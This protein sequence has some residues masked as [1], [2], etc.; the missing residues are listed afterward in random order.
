MRSTHVYLDWDK[1]GTFHQILE[2]LTPLG[3]VDWVRNRR[4]TT[5]SQH[6]VQ[7]HTTPD[8]RLGYVDSGTWAYTHNSNLRTKGGTPH[9]QLGT[10]EHTETTS[11][12]NGTACQPKI[13]HAG[14]CHDDWSTQT[15][16]CSRSTMSAGGT[17]PTCGGRPS[18]STR[19]PRSSPPVVL[20]RDLVSFTVHLS[21]PVPILPPVS[22]RCLSTQ[23]LY[24]D[25]TREG[26]AIYHLELTTDKVV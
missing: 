11:M 16:T 5:P 24:R 6:R 26:V 2:S 7:S 20:G 23:T 17:R 14:G 15:P 13:R 8:R 19:E 1:D 12:W 4:H 21:P 3:R 25:G 22:P 9:L 18:S 10:R